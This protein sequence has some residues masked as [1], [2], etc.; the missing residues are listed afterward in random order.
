MPVDLRTPSNNLFRKVVAAGV[1][2]PHPPETQLFHRFVHSRGI[3]AYHS[4][5][6]YRR[7]FQ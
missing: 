4:I 7:A 3:P 1:N 2:T 6:E 5:D